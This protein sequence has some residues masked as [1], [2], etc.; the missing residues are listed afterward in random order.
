VSFT[1][2]QASNVTWNWKTQY[3][4][5]FSESGVSSDFTGTVITIDGTNYGIN[6]LS[7]AFWW[8]SGSV[9]TFAYQSP[10]VVSANGKQYVWTGTSGLST[11]QAGSLTVSTNG[12][13]IGSYKTQ[14]YLTVTSAYGTTGGQGWY[15]SGSTAYAT[16][17]AGTVD[18]GN[19]TLR[20]FTT[21]GGDASGTNFAQSNSI[22]MS[23]AKVAV[24][25]WKTQ[26]SVTFTC[27]GL[28]SSASST[29]VTVNGVPKAYGD[30][31][32]SIWVDNGL[33]TTYSYSNVSSS[34]TGKRF[35]LTSV[36]GLTSPITVSGP[37][38]VTGNYE[39]QYQITFTQSGVGSDF[40]G[41]VVTIDSTGYS[42]TSL[43]VSFWWNASSSHSFSYGS[44]LTVN[45]SESYLW[46]STTGGLSTLQSDL[47]TITSSGTVTGNYAVHFK[48][49]VTFDPGVG[50]D[51]T[52]TV[53]TVDGTNY[54]VTALPV[55]F[56]WDSGSVHTFTYQSPLVVTTNGKQYVLIGVNA[57]SPYT[58]SG[59]VT[60]T[61]NYKTQYYLT[62]TTSPS[63]VNSPSGTGWYDAGTNAPI[64]TSAF[65]YIVPGSSRY[66]FNGW[67]TAN[68]AEI[69]NPTGS[70]TT[71]KM[72][73]AKTVTAT[74]AVQ[75]YLTFSQSG[76][77]SDFTGTVLIIDGVNYAA[78]SLPKSFWWDSSSVHTFAYQSPLVVTANVKS[79]GWTSTTGLST[80]QSTSMTVSA[81]GS[82]TGNY[83]IQYY[84]TVQTDP[85]SITTLSGQGWYGASSTAALT[86]PSVAGYQF[87]Y[88]DVDGASQGSGVTTITITM[89]GPHVATAHYTVLS[90]SVTI[91]PLST[92]IYGGNSVSFTSTITGGISPYTYQWYVDGSPIS[93][94]T[95]SSWTFTP[96]TSGIYYVSLKVTDSKGNTVQSAQARITVITVPVGGYSTAL[97]QEASISRI[98]AYMALVA[99]F[100]VVLS[101]RKRKRK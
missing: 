10:L 63:G 56:W 66:R 96:P 37:T 15:D 38:T 5:T 69:A 57:S 49:Q 44:P 100:G 39:I 53:L 12:T 68:M 20:V 17:N 50:V 32:Y 83:Q 27:S 91:S 76:V 73:Q 99:L 48:Y 31:P 8:D 46:V 43:P 87:N 81:S 30:L 84:L 71:V 21:W 85:A 13:V 89:N 14:Y 6:A 59:P 28:D 45:A 35:I 65:V 11:S 82:V 19:G 9:H 2:T 42:T 26:Y 92:V 86:A 1:I 79:Y 41:T 7:A 24:A 25:N 34:T 23:D 52:G 80:L 58:V 51:F 40:A 3:Q 54:G 88:W 97:T 101:L 33:T 62:M 74:Y 29:V 90:L 72:D 98:A 47:L 60:I 16:L 70:P 36:T 64:S 55:S 77:G 18:Q 22:S 93:G 78:S 4:I 75:Y 61:G 95:S 94:L 67:T